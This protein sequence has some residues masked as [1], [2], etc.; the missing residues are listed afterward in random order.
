[1]HHLML[2][3]LAILVV[4]CGVAASIGLST[5]LHEW[6]LAAFDATAFPAIGRVAYLP[7]AL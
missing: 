6:A 5:T 7:P 1:M 2:F 3:S 4:A